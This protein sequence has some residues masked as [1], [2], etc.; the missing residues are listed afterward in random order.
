MKKIRLQIISPN[1]FNT[2]HLH[3]FKKCGYKTEC[4]F[5]IPS[6]LKG[7]CRVSGGRVKNKMENHPSIPSLK[8]RGNFMNNPG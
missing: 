7:R 2:Y 6:L 3:A 5:N 4:N 1:L 8:R